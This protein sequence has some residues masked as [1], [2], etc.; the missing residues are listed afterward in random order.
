MVDDTETI[1]FCSG[2]LV[3]LEMCSRQ[4]FTNG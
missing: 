4:A 1:W 3:L 2:G